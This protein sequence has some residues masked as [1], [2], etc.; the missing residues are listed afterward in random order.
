MTSIILNSIVFL[1]RLM[2]ISLLILPLAYADDKQDVMDYLDQHSDG[3]A[4][5]AMS[6][7]DYAELGYLEVQSSALLQQTLQQAGFEIESNVAG[8][9]SAF[10]AS[11]GQ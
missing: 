5:L 11:Y 7:W 3:Y 6:I 8:I 4:E 2:F 10:I 1:R 9:P